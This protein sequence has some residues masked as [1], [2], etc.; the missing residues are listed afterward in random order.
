M[1]ANTFAKIKNIDFDHNVAKEMG[2]SI[3]ESSMI[4][5]EKVFLKLI[6]FWV[7]ALQHSEQVD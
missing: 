4:D 7:V 2:V 6:P 1:F 3:S 5:L